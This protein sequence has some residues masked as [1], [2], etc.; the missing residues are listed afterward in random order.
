M[1]DMD[2]V[3]VASDSSDKTSDDAQ[4]EMTPVK[5]IASRF[6]GKHEQSL[7]T[8]KFRT[9]RDFFP[10]KQSARVGSEKPKFEAQTQ[11]DNSLDNVRV[12]AEKA[13]FEA[14]L[15]WSKMLSPFSPL[16][17]H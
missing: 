13:K 11:P 15:R 3:A 16:H 6:E 1:V 2:K 8:L 5:S 4:R 7:D 17:T 9:L 10:E 14:Q 12:G